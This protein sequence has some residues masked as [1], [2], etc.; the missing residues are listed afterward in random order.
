[1]WREVCSNSYSFWIHYHLSST[2][3][4]PKHCW[5][6]YFV[7]VLKCFKLKRIH[8]ARKVVY[9]ISMM[10]L[11]VN[12]S[13]F[14]SVNLIHSYFKTHAY[15]ETESICYQIDNSANVHRVIKLAL[16]RGGWLLSLTRKIKTNCRRRRKKNKNKK[17]TF[18]LF[19]CLFKFIK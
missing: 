15:S 10:L 3:H 13:V 2:N 12:T 4:Q 14:I 17:K 5:K 19:W 16:N 11:Y 9:L 6:S 18:S 7:F 8:A 1:M